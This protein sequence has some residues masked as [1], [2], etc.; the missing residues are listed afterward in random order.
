MYV[1][2]LGKAH[3]FGNFWFIF[4]KRMERHTVKS[5]ATFFSPL[6]LNIQ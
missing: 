1:I 3:N 5:R 4:P 6:S 2:I